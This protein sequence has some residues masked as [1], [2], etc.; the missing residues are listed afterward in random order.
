MLKKTLLLG[1]NSDMLHKIF[2]FDW[3]CWTPNLFVNDE[4]SRHPAGT[5]LYQ[6]F[7]AIAMC[8]LSGKKREKIQKCNGNVYLIDLSY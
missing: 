3:N 1:S 7:L 4:T 6:E 5:P 8:C 2:L